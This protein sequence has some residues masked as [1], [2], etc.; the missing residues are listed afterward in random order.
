METFLTTKGN[1]WA[2][3]R[4][5]FHCYL[6]DNQKLFGFYVALLIRIYEIWLYI[7]PLQLTFY[8]LVRLTVRCLGVLQRCIFQQ[9]C[10]LFAIAKYTPLEPCI[11]QKSILLQCRACHGRV[12]V[13]G[14]MPSK[15][16]AHTQSPNLAPSMC[17]LRGLEEDNTLVNF[18]DT[19]RD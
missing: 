9:L 16:T 11:V 4:Y 17:R 1:N 2:S 15:H 10:R 19:I 5:S 12:K 13:K 14:S 6:P 3:M 8:E 18:P 7:V